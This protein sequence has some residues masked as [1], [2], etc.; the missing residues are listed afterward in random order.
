MFSGVNE[1]NIGLNWDKQLR[2][3]LIQ[4]QGQQLRHL[5]K[6]KLISK[7][8]QDL[9]LAGQKSKTYSLQLYLEMNS[10]R[11]AFQGLLPKN[12]FLKG[13]LQMTLSKAL[14]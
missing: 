13:H 10:F 14:K 7:K 9:K 8:E 12:L 5:Q 3:V 1:Q 6:R 4:L 2:N 11:G